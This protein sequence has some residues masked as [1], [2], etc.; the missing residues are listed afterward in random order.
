[1]A[2]CAAFGLGAW[3]ERA[4]MSKLGWGFVLDPLLLIIRKWIA[5]SIERGGILSSICIQEG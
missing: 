5:V 1:M 4:R 3:T 2:R